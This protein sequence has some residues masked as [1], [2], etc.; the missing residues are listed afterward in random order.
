M[1]DN[2][3]QIFWILAHVGILENKVTDQPAKGAAIKQL[4]SMEKL[5]LT[6]FYGVLKYKIWNDSEDKLNALLSSL[7]QAEYLGLLIYIK[8]CDMGLLVV[9]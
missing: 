2:E 1:V 8:L 9:Y 4:D 7:K 3:L 6:D 5:P